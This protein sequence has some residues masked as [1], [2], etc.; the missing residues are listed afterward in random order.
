MISNKDLVRTLNLKA[1]DEIN[2]AT[3]SLMAISDEE[4]EA[5]T[6]FLSQFGARCNIETQRMKVKSELTICNIQDVN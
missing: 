3:I 5:I 6:A 4:L 1:N 2:R